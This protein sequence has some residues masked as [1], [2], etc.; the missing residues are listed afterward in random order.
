MPTKGKS[1]CLFASASNLQMLCLIPP[2]HS[3]LMFMPRMQTSGLS[4][5][6]QGLQAAYGVP[7]HQSRVGFTFKAMINPTTPMTMLMMPHCKGRM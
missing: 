4:I 3:Y 1:E 5:P 2:E 6:I 7:K